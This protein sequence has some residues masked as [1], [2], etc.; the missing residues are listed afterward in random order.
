MADPGGGG[1]LPGI[2][3]GDEIVFNQET[4]FNGDFGRHVKESSRKGHL[5]S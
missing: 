1:P 3:K 5:S 4:L 2:L